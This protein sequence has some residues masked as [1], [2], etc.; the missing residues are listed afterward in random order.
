MDSVMVLY[1]VSLMFSETG[2]EVNTQILDP[3][4]SLEANNPKPTPEVNNSVKYKDQ[5]K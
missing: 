5:S 3:D 1:H 4:L 2:H